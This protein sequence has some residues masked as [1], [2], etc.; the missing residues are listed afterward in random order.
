MEPVQ[1]TVTQ[2]L[3]GTH[4]R[5]QQKSPAL[6]AHF[7]SFVVHALDTHAPLGVLQMNAAP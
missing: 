3:P 5:A 2:Q 4:L 6:A 1:S 7:L